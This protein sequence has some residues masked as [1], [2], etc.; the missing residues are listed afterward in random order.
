MD[1]YSITVIS[2]FTI[3]IA[4]IIGWI[5]FKKINPAYFPF[6]YFIWLGLLNEIISFILIKN[7]QRN[8]VNNN[9]YVLAEA[10]LIAWQFKKWKIFERLRFLFPTIL[11]LFSISWIIEILVKSIRAELF[12]YMIFYS[13]VI[14]LL[15]VQT[16]N[17]LIITERRNILKNSIFLIC[18]AF[19]INY[20]LTVL[21][22]SFWLYGINV[23]DVFTR[24]I[25]II[26]PALNVFVNLIY[27]LAVLWMPTKQRFTLPS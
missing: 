20:T 12:Y 27:A 6:L 21:V 1:D 14:V 25:G 2:G 26:L 23:S 5:R 10:V 7:N 4:A 9:I 18:T 3:V 15:S 11:F 19:V 13:F 24:K 17:R 22:L 16:I 8:T